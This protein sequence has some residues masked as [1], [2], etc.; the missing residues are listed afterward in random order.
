MK[1]LFDTAVI[2][3]QQGHL[4]KAEALYRQILRQI[5][6]QS[7]TLNALGMLLY[8]TGKL[9]D[10]ITLFRKAIQA[11]SDMPH[12]YLNLAEAYRQ[13]K[14]FEEA[15]RTIKKALK[16]QPDFPEA[17]FSLASLYHDQNR[18]AEAIVGYKKVLQLSPNFL[19][20]YNALGV[21]LQE[22]G[23]LQGAENVL[24]QALLQQ[25]HSPDINLN[26]ANTLYKLNRK[27]ESQELYLK[28]LQ[29]DNANPQAHLG[30]AQLGL[31]SLIVSEKNDQEI[32]LHLSLAAVQLANTP[33]FLTTMGIF[34]A[35]RGLW[36]SS[37]ELLASALALKPTPDTAYQYACGKKF[38]TEDALLVSAIK[39]MQS[40][41]RGVAAPDMALT[42]FSY[43]K[44]LNDLKRFSEA[45]VA[46]KAGND[47][48]NMEIGHDQDEVA[49][50]VERLIKVFS[51]DFIEKCSNPS[52]AAG[53]R[54]IFIIGMPRSGTTL[55]EQVIS[56][57]PQILGAGELFGMAVL[58]SK[59]P[60]LLS[61]SL[62]YPEAFAVAS[63]KDVGRLAN[64][65]ISELEGLF[66]G[67][68]SRITDKLPVN[69]WRIGLIG[70]L[71]PSAYLI[72][73]KRDPMDCCLSNYFQKYADGHSFAYDLGN[74]GHYYRQYEKL[75]A[76][77][78]EVFPG[79]IKT[80]QYENL[81]AD[82]E[83]WS[84][85]LI[86]C[87]GLEWDDACLAPHKL[88][89]S[90]RTSSYWQ[91]RQPIY[92]TSVQRWKN[93]EAHL[94]PLKEALGYQE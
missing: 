80:L 46:Y 57:H 74:L 42:H 78:K 55:T 72:E 82:P 11:R 83:Y 56:S 86:E 14:N 76:H 67:D 9:D 6:H 22:G 84:R 90:V 63:S 73:V 64:E 32:E 3:H 88:E 91:V 52:A 68:Y 40:A 45:F 28:C 66:P 58:E 75:M 59:I 54:L 10:A 31:D 1:N 93:Y 41:P 87:I 43:G 29:Y 5:P 69:F 20:A 44:M 94:A 35:R 12:L 62:G 34:K 48:L 51:K 77:W 16:L 70:M 92:K 17:S 60:S 38:D 26:L 25:P 18:L 47:L 2:L 13:G 61:S 50:K 30:L 39:K 85:W 36:E 53:E 79:R 7:D 23:D 49:L 37:N 89:R 65:Y 27:D 15:F 19:P 8:Q 24:R 4:A 33:E 21:A 81:I 71:F